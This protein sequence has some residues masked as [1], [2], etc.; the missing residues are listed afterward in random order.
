MAYHFI[1]SILTY[2]R[3]GITLV[4]PEDSSPSA[5]FDSTDEFGSTLIYTSPPLVQTLAADLSGR[6]L[7]AKTRVISTSSGLSYEHS[8]AFLGRYGIP[9][10][11]VYGVIEI[12]LP[13]GEINVPPQPHASIGSPLPGYEVTILNTSGVECPRGEIGRL[14]IRG[15]GMF[16]AYLAPFRPRQQVLVEGWFLTGDLAMQDASGTITVCGREK[17]VISTGGNKVFP[18]EVEAV[19]TSFPGVK[20][21]R[22]F[23]IA[24]PLIGEVVAAEIVTSGSSIDLDALRRYCYD[25]LSPFKVPKDLRIV[26]ALPVTDSGKIVRSGR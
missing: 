1:V 12:G 4:L 16:D 5:L 22:A 2:V 10:S 19:V 6:S 18:E 26:E 20:A 21:A 17:S 7:P 9:V 13:I 14:A 23:G 8:R 25:K 24:Q 11:Q 3:F 15:P